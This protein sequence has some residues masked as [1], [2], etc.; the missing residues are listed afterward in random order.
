MKTKSEVTD[1]YYKELYPHLQELEKERKKLKKKILILSSFIL[2]I[3]FFIAF[4]IYTHFF[5]IASLFFDGVIAVF[6]LSWLYKHLTKT[7]VY[8]FKNNI[9]SPLIQEIGSSFTYEPFKYI[10]PTYF[11]RAKFFTSPPD[12]TSGNDY[13]SGKID[14]IKIS[15]SD[16]HA[17]KKHTD[18]K[19]RTSWNTMFQGLFVVTEFPK[20]FHS[21]TLVLPDFAQ[22]IF[23]E[24]IGSILQENNF[25][26]KKLVKM[27]SSQFEK[28][29]V[30]YSED[31]IEARYIL[32]PAFMQRVLNFKR[33]SK[34]PLYLSFR[35]NVMYM[36]ISYNKD[37]FEPS[38][39]RSLLGY[40]IAM[41]YID[42]LH[43]V[44]GLVDEL[45]L[46]QKLWSKL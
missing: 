43:L 14:G 32:T 33:R 23:G 22:N 5:S 17:E 36:G 18:S 45:K 37:M 2:F 6:L 46:N 42:T 34:A 44:M 28:E 12:R 11:N 1:F 30:V 13:V 20:H 21:T 35:Y 24:F 8:R 27:D 15:F 41:E 38:V 9:I 19:G 40:K 4:Y 3:T 31:Q 26:R 10:M 25:S 29:F 16:F 39:F 7:Y